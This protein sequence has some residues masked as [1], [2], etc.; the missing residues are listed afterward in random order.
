MTVDLVRR[1]LSALICFTV[2]SA[3]FRRYVSDARD[4][5]H[6]TALLNEGQW[7][8][9]SRQRPFYK[10]QPP[11]C[12]MHEYLGP[13]L[14]HCAGNR[15][16]LFVGDSNV[17]QLFWAVARKLNHGK[18][19]DLSRTATTHGD[20]QFSDRSVDLRFVWD[21]LLNGS[22][23]STELAIYS[24][25]VGSG[26]AGSGRKKKGKKEQDAVMIVLGAGLWHARQFADGEAVR[27]FKSSVDKVVSYTQ[28]NDGSAWK[29]TSPFDGWEGIGDQVFFLPVEEP[30]YERLSPSRRETI[31]PEEIDQMN[32]Y[33]R[34][35]SPGK[36]L[37]IPWVNQVM[38]GKRR[39]A[40]EQSGIHVV[41]PIANR[42]ADVI[43]NL[44]CNAKVDNAAG[45]PYER[46]CC[47]KYT[48]GNWFQWVLV[49][50][51][52]IALPMAI[53][54]L[55]RSTSLLL[56]S[57]IQSVLPP[58]AI[59]GLALVYCF[60]A[61]RS[62]LFSKVQKTFYASESLMLG[63]FSI[64]VGFATISRTNEA[65][66]RKT[67]T[68][69][70]FLPSVPS[71]MSREQTDEW[72][73]WMSII[74]MLHH[75]TD[76]SGQLPQYIILRLAIASYL[77]IHAYG[78]TMYFYQQE[79]Y[80]L[81]RIAGVLIRSNLFPVLMSYQMYNNFLMYMFPALSTFWFLV[82]LATMSFGSE[83]NDK[84]RYLLAKLALSASL[85]TLSHAHAQPTDP[86]FRGMR[87]IFGI[88]WNAGDWRKMVSL[89]GYIPFVGAWTALL[90]IWH[91]KSSSMSGSRG[92]NR[93]GRAWTSSILLDAM[94]YLQPA[95]LTASIVAV[96][97]FI[98][99]IG[100][101]PDEGDYHWWSAIISPVPILS[102]VALRN[103]HPV[104]RDH[105]SAAF[106]WLGRCS[107]ELW[108]LSFH[109]LR[110]AD[111]R[112]VLSTGLFSTG[113]GSLQSDRWREAVL[114]IPILLWT[115]WQV[116]CATRQITAWFVEGNGMKKRFVA[117]LGALWL[118]NL[119]SVSLVDVGHI[120]A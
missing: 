32:E 81:R 80:S 96:P 95:A 87:S 115:A 59:I 108:I 111:G 118:L 8:D 64:A 20:I 19:V 97:V 52:L 7:I 68:K 27:E 69:D 110:A 76:T 104:L 117:L 102:Y 101:S 18:A 35:L 109:V 74:V 49:V 89:D 88:N 93:D 116:S 37:T 99:L 120:T 92:S 86:I 67:S 114:I 107:S 44:R 41:E 26:I 63:A 66:A 71:F 70:I 48:S 103:A 84:P 39:R 54:M 58:L 24:E 113:N 62:Q 60:F 72:K 17:R 10:W 46:T 75:W 11:K 47:S 112:G 13:D 3:L 105:Y 36:G 83:L 61:D 73:G 91:Q 9:E 2:L 82:V 55:P 79:D 85:V 6:C 5:Y 12:L 16:M 100:R 65:Q 56:P 31:M 42:R 106:A 30:I 23:L 34:T 28:R 14:G 1:V 4:P 57:K 21:P 43:L 25:N 38:T 51:S 33:L 29:A 22:T 94:P 50:V 90:H 78:H 40:Y 98:L 45:A 77:F 119:V 15:Q 53:L